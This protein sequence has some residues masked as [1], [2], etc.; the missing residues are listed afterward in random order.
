[1][2]RTPP[3]GSVLA[4]AEEPRLTTAASRRRIAGSTAQIA[5]QP[6][7]M[8]PAVAAATRRACA[9]VIASMVA[10]TL[11]YDARRG[12]ANP[13]VAATNAADI[14]ARRIFGP[15]RWRGSTT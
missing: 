14:T 13:N 1:M 15:R 3:P 12:I 4:T 2:A 10:H 6:A 9:H 11:P 5:I 8:L 7:A